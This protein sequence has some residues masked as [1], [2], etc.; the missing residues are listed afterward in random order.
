[1][2]CAVIL[3]TFFP[4]LGRRQQVRHGETCNENLERIFQAKEDWIRKAAFTSTGENGEEAKSPRL[5]DLFPDDP[6]E[7]PAGGI[8]TLGPL[9][10]LN[11]EIIPPV[12][13]LDGVDPDGN[14]VN[15][16]GEGLHIHRR[17][18]LQDPGSGVWFRDPAFVFPKYRK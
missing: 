9:A 6:P 5:K 12:C 17:S 14:G 1:V 2:L 15:N 13:S 7:C 16:D 18:C 11:G 4:V 3:A 10:D 8:Y